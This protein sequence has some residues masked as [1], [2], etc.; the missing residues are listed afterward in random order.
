MDSIIQ[1]LDPILILNKIIFWSW[2]SQPS[3]MVAPRSRAISI[4]TPLPFFVE[5]SHKSYFLPVNLSIAAFSLFVMSSPSLRFNL[6]SERRI[7]S[8]CKDRIAFTFSSQFSKLLVIFKEL[9][10]C[11][12]MLKFIGPSASP[13]AE[14]TDNRINARDLVPYHATELRYRY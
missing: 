3:I 10:F 1:C 11:D 13:A 4:P 9:Q 14:F 7:I 6:R 12:A 2:S 5:F 8:V